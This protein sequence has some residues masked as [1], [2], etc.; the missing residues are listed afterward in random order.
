M[1]MD[2]NNPETTEERHTGGLLRFIWNEVPWVQVFLW[3]LSTRLLLVVVALLS[4]LIIEPGK[5]SNGAISFPDVFL[6]WDSDWYRSIVFNGY[7]FNPGE[8][9]NV[10]FF[11]LYPFLI[12]CLTLL[13]LGDV[14]AAFLISNVGLLISSGLIWAIVSHLYPNRKDI[15]ESAVLLFLF[16]P[17]SFFY[18]IYYTEGLFL[19]L[20]SGSV[21]LALKQH[22]VWAG[23]VAALAVLSRSVGIFL[24][25]VIFLEYL[26]A[27]RIQSTPFWKAAGCGV[28]ISLI[29]FLGLFIYMIYLQLV[30]GN[31]MAFSEVQGAWGRSIAPFWETIGSVRYHERFYQYWFGGS[32]VIGFVVC[33]I[34]LLARLRLSLLVYSAALVVFYLS[35]GLLESIPRYFSSIFPLY[36]VLGWAAV[37]VSVARPL[38]IGSFAMLSALSVILFVNGYWFT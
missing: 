38:L 29:P 26:R 20:A 16:N 2:N 11:P 4:V 33:A 27:H 25:G 31:A 30:I 19:A 36:F 37:K 7:S 6:K 22:F 3:V 21:F 15:C 5:F 12:Y 13:G 32:V 17:L 18:S 23:I 14:T 10:A 9:S 1:Q 24:C 28:A 35:F 8:Q 34:A